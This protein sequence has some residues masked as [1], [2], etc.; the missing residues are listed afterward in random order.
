MN[1]VLDTSVI[2]N[3][4]NGSKL[5]N[6]IR[7]EREWRIGPIVV[8]ECNANITLHLLEKADYWEAI[9]DSA[10]DAAEFIRLINVYNLGEGEAECIA[11]C[12]N[13][14]EVYFY[15]DDRRARRV[16]LEILGRER[17]SGTLG[18]LRLVVAGNRM[19]AGEA[20]RSYVL[21]KEAGGFLPNISESYFE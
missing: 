17:V 21:M 5:C 16:A 1:A 7:W 8:R 11:Y 2:I 9:D 13:Y 3:L 4:F 12:L 19:N 14:T 15:C 20:Y 6:V 10:I 18:L